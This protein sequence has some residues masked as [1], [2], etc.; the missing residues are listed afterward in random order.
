MS[1]G[2][3]F[4]LYIHSYCPNSSRSTLTT[5]SQLLRVCRRWNKVLAAMPDLWRDLHFD[6][7]YKNPPRLNSLQKLARRAGDRCRSLQVPWARKFD[8]SSRRFNTLLQASRNVRHLNLRT[9]DLPRPPGSAL[10]PVLNCLLPATVPWVLA[11]LTSLVLIGPFDDAFLLAL[12]RRAPGLQ[13]I[14]V[15]RQWDLN[16]DRWPVMSQL[17][18]LRLGRFNENVT[19]NA[20]SLSRRP[21]SGDVE[22]TEVS[23]VYARRPH[24]QPRAAVT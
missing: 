16:E 12:L 6:R 13:S 8:L 14:E 17:R 1:S 2:R 22:L 24:S 18:L 9:G 4:C 21:A 19:L 11:N 15:A 23:T 5:G 7:W 3:R 10:A 20:V